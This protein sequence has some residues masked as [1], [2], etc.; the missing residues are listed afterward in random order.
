VGEGWGRAL[1]RTCP[2]PTNTIVIVSVVY[3]QGLS[4]NLLSFFSY[5]HFTSIYPATLSSFL[6][7]CS[8][9]L[10]NVILNFGSSFPFLLLLILFN[11][12]IINRLIY[13][14]WNQVLVLIG[15][16]TSLLIVPDVFIFKKTFT[17]N[18]ANLAHGLK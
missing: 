18:S 12:P 7:S 14:K 6:F 8:L 10:H 5:T 4:Q 9:Q 3:G 1:D 16:Y 2:E 15:Q 17:K 11:M 13:A